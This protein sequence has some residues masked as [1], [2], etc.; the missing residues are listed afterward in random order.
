MYWFNPCGIW[1]SFSSPLNNFFKIQKNNKR[2]FRKRQP[3]TPLAA[4]DKTQNC[5]KVQVDQL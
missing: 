5:K 2:M 3:D 4:G 1:L